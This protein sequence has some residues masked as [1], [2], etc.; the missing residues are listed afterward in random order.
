MKKIVSVL[1]VLVMVLSMAACGAAK[2]DPLVGTWKGS[3][4]MTKLLTETLEAEGMTMPEGA[5]AIGFDMILTFTEEGTVT[6]GV[7]EASVTAMATKL[8]DF[9]LEITMSELKGQGIDLSAL[10]IDEE[11]LR[12]QLEQSFDVNDLTG[13]LDLAE[14]GYYLYKDGK[15][16]AGDTKEELSDVSESEDYMVVELSGNQMSIL[17]IISDGEKATDEMPSM[18]PIVMTKQ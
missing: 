3:I 7:D 9:M 17:D 6:L 10:G 1:L 16:Y 2:K 4:D 8:V 11:T 13:S 5:P 14:N 15:I 18:F 12:A